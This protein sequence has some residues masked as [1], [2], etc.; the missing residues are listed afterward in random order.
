[1]QPL[2]VI[3]ATFYSNLGTIL[4]LLY[5]PTLHIIICGDINFN[6]QI[7]SKIGKPTGLFI[8]VI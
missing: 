6:Y 2:L 8:T 3:L 1:M 5:T 4:Q 7:E